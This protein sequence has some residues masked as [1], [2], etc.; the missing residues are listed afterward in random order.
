MRITEIQYVTFVNETF[1]DIIVRKL[2]Y[3]QDSHRHRQSSIH[4][5]MTKTFNHT[6]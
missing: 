1:D 6:V 5:S 2:I 4:H 3:R